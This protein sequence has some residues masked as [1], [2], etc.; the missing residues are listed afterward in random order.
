MAVQS[1]LKQSVHKTTSPKQPQQNEL[2]V[3]LK[4]QGVGEG[5]KERILRHCAE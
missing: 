4:Q 1:Q 2:E 3:W 5:G